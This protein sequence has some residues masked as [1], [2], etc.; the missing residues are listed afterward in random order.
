MYRKIFDMVNG[1]EEQ[2]KI[3]DWLYKLMIEDENSLYK[4]DIKVS[5]RRISEQGDI[6]REEGE[7]I[8][9]AD[10][11]T[12]PIGTKSFVQNGCWKGEIVSNEKKHLYMPQIGEMREIK[13]GSTGLNIEIE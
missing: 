2:S 3:T 12:L 11:Q 4:I 7:Y 5:K 13:V 10:L 8:E 6:Y 1:S 9:N